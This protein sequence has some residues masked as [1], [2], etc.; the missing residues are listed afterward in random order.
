LN[1]GAFG[2]DVRSAEGCPDIPYLGK[3]MAPFHIKSQV[4]RQMQ[5]E[6]M[7]ALGVFEPRSG[8]ATSDSAPEPRAKRSWRQSEVKRVIS[9]AEQAGLQSYRV[10]IAPD[11]TI[12][13]VVGAP[14]DTADDPASYGSLG[15]P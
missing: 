7:T 11:G 9:A 13:I 15:A 5:L 10:E 4:L 6:P 1:P 14:A 8:E 12:S 2:W 3:R